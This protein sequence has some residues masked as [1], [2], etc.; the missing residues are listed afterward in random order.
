VYV[1]VL[2]AEQGWSL[3]ALGIVFAAHQATAGL[4]GPAQGWALTRFGYRPVALVGMTILAI[5]LLGLGSAS[6]LLVFGVWFAVGAVGQYMAGFLTLVST[7][8]SWFGRRSTRALG[9]MQTGL[10]LAGLAAPAVAWAI[11]SYGWRSAFVASGVLVAVIGL[12]LAAAIRVGPFGAPTRGDPEAR[13]KAGASYR[14]AVTSTAFWRLAL[15]HALAMVVLHGVNVY[16]VLFITRTD[17]PLQ[18][19]AFVV[20]TM[21]VT[22]VIGQL[23]SGS[24][25]EHIP[26]RSVAAGCMVVHAIALVI[27]VTARGPAGLVSFALLHGLAW[28][29]RGPIMQSIRVAYFGPRAYPR[30]MGLSLTIATVGAVAGPIVVARWAEA[31]G[32]FAPSFLGLATIAILSATAF[33]TA[34][35][36]SVPRRP[37]PVA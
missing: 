24:W 31:A 16:A 9:V 2:E 25:P 23:T 3:T 26:M 30:V 32:G 13:A 4:I 19:A 28:G 36:G 18:L 8:V 35:P 6:S 29:V 34:R 37:S 11:A 17:V 21:T 14:A 20:P 10:S 1:P 33:G 12:P 22:M 15:G 7:V 27:L 5:S